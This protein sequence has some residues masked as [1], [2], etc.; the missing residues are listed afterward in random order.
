MIARRVRSMGLAVEMVLLT[1]GIPLIDMLDDAC[2]RRLLFSVLVTE[3]HELHGSC[4]VHVLNGPN[5]QGTAYTTTST[6]LSLSM[7]TTEKS[8]VKAT[9]Y[10]T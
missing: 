10:A 1:P 5:K 9:A 8:G 6:A 3:Q 7:C 2:R 4:T